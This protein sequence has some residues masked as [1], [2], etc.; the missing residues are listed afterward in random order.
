MK[1]YFFIIFLNI[2]NIGFSSDKYIESTQLVY[3]PLDQS[4]LINFQVAFYKS[5]PS[6]GLQWWPSENL[7]IAGVIY[8]KIGYFSHDFNLYHNISIGY[9]NKDIKWFYSS[10]NFI[11]FS[12]HKIKYSD[13][14]SK[15]INC[16]Y[17]SRYNY[18]SFI[19][20][21][22]LN[23][24]FWKDINNNFI[25]FIASYNMGRKIILEFKSDFNKNNIFNS[26]NFSVPL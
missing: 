21:Y 9:Y 8:P 15:W 12:L 13:N 24:Y 17:K 2:I 6:F 4:S 26:F 20:G 14:Q 18:K 11:E 23:Y 10:S 5:D 3:K 19:I 16:A 22:D 25:S 1:F 7:Q